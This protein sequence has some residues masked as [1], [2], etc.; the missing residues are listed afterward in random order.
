MSIRDGLRR[1]PMVSTVPSGLPKQTLLFYIVSDVDQIVRTEMRSLVHGLADATSWT[2]GP[3]R[4][5]QDRKEPQEPADLP[6]ETVGGCLQIYTALPPWSLPHD[7]DLQHLHE[8]ETLVTRLCDFS[9]HAG[10]EIEFEL[11]GEYVG[12]I[13][14]G[15]MDRSLSIGLLGEW[16]RKLSH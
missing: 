1:T 14:N 16:R 13:E 8:V 9:R 15:E 4:F 7:V 2:V 12:A 5:V 10:L 11:D 3:P 6:V